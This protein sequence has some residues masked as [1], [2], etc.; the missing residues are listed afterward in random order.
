MAK[1]R[2]IRCASDLPI[3]RAVRTNP[4]PFEY[5]SFLVEDELSAKR[6]ELIE[7]VLDSGVKAF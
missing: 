1:P 5:E 7:R 4:Y 3:Q 2:Q 6:A